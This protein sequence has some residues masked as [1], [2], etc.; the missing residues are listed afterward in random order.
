MLHIVTRITQ[1]VNS[2]Q[3]SIFSEQCILVLSFFDLA[4]ASVKQNVVY[5]LQ[6]TS[7]EERS[8]QQKRI[9]EEHASDRWRNRGADRSSDPGYTGGG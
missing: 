5:D 9:A 7:Y 6:S 3:A 1:R 8:A 2:G 4:K